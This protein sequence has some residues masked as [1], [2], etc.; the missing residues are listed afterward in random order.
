M[1]NELTQTKR[2]MR[3]YIQSD[4]VKAQLAMVLPKHLTPDRMARV[5]L[6]SILRTPALLQCS[7]E[8]LLQAMMICSQV[9][10]EPDGRN[11][12]LIPFGD[13]VTVIFD[14]KGLVAL[15]RRNG[16]KGIHSDVVCE[17]DIFDVSFDGG[18]KLTHKIDYR[19]PRGSV[20]AAYC[21]FM[22]DGEADVEVMQRDE[23]E[24]IRKRSRAGSSGPWVTDWNEM[25]KKTVL[26]RASK[27]WPLDPEAADAI[28]ADADSPVQPTGPTFSTN[29]P[30]TTTVV[31]VSTVP[32]EAPKRVGRPPGSKNKPKVE[33]ED[34]QIPGAEVVEPQQPEVPESPTPGQSTI[35]PSTPAPEFAL[36]PDQEALS[37]AWNTIVEQNPGAEFDDLKVYGQLALPE[38]KIDWDS[39]S[40]IHEIPDAIAA[41]LARVPKNIA[42]RVRLQIGKRTGKPF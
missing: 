27:K 28:A 12:H 7:P 18:P 37:K 25:A 16:V 38:S 9:G 13:K 23:I 11:A 5:A 22:L 32:E 36:T 41:V 3:Q 4:A 42:A 8:S 14:Y 1:A 15:A 2:D 40:G 35:E 21:Y 24:A 31:D 26:R 33:P 29:A 19:K 10:L 39:I 6:T 20:Y 34:D 17:N 30:T